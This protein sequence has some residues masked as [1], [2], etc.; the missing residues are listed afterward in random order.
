MKK[1]QKMFCCGAILLVLFVLWTVLVSFVDVQAIGPQ[2]SEVGLSA[3]NQFVQENIGVSMPLY[4]T[5]DWLSLIPIGFVVGFAVFGVV[6][7]IKRKS[8]LKVDREILLLGAFYL[9]VAA[10]YVIFEVIIIN[11]RPILIDGQLEA[12][13]PSSTTV[14]VLCVMLTAAIQLNCRIKNKVMRSVVL[15]GIVSFVAFMI[16]CRIASGVHW[17]TDIIGGMLIS[18]GLLTIYYSVKKEYKI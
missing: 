16:I 12:S 9:T 15:C 4:V 18:A 14:L 8:I 2:G 17:I 3:L 6:Q 11:Y 13:Y 10:V 7:L 5:T 1:N